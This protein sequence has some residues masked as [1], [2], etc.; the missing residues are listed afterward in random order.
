VAA[1]RRNLELTLDGLE[2]RLIV[3]Q[4]RVRFWR[5]MR[6]RHESVT[7]I[8]CASQGEHAEEMALRAV[9][10]AHSPLHRARVAAATS[11]AGPAPGRVP[12]SR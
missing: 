3:N 11:A 4:S 8:A 7:A 6:D 9:P 2:D 1:E 5:E 12:A 10:A